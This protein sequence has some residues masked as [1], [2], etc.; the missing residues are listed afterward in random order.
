M[1]DLVAIV[2]EPVA[3]HGAY[4]GGRDNLAEDMA[5]IRLEVGN[6]EVAEHG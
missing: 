2:G 1:Q 4:L 6:T 3:S 5:G